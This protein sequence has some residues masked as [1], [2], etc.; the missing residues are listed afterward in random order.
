MQIY[1]KLL[2]LLSD[3]ERKNALFLLVM[4][5]IMALLDMMGV[6]SILPFMAVLTNPDI[7]ETNSFLNNIFQISKNIGVENKQQFLFL[8]G[9]VV[10][11]L[12][13]FSLIFKALTNYLQVRFVQL[14]QYNIS[15]RLVEGYLNQP[16][17]WFL[18]RNS[19]DLGKTILSEVDQVVGSGIAPAI[20]LIAKGMVI[21]ALITLLIIA[22]PKLAIVVGFTLSAVYGL[23]FYLIRRYLN[24]IGKERLRSNEL[25]Y[26]SISEAFGAA[27]QVK[28]GGLEQTY[29]GRFS[30]PAQI[31]AM[32]QV[33]FKVLN[34]LPRFFLEAIAFGGILLS[35]LYLMGR[36]GNFN[37][38]LPIISLY[39]FA[40]YR[41]LPAIQQIYASFTR[42]TFVGPSL[43]KL[44]EDIKNLSPYKTNQ[45]QAVLTLNKKITFNNIDYNYPKSS[46]TILRNINLSI[47]AKTTV[48]IVG[49]TGSG[50]TTTVDIILG[51]LNPQKGNLKV[52]E[53]II[54]KQN[55]KSWQRSI[56]YV[57]QE[58]YLSDDTIA[59][60][61]AFGVD[62]K[63]V[64]QEAVERA[65]KIANLHQ[66]VI[67]E[68]P[69]QYQTTIGERGVRL[70]G[71][72]RQR[73]GIAR[74]LYHDTKLLY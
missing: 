38:I 35:I 66:F 9:I 40:G 60:N 36:S 42:L 18:S 16:Y 54:T 45:D 43:D 28:V 46:R 25:R 70:S 3:P 63:I 17:T 58:I 55:S 20:D 30:N 71:G 5:L 61:I 49:A 65:A 6:A 67:E 34:Q 37:T 41:L 62:D 27:K 53:K 48:G 23:I 72:Q 39:V 7:I 13:V 69:K 68:L 8:L 12:L 24:R 74:D 2:F 21:I 56:G 44:H 10:F 4:I 19:A 15:K 26:T 33:Y 11:S 73:I 32:T 51:L 52:D 47:N 29:I 50:K 22:D 64:K 31:Y 59:A 1:K 57:P 14:G